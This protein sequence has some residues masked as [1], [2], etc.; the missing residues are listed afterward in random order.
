MYPRAWV[1]VAAEPI[2]WRFLTA[3]GVENTLYMAADSA[4]LTFRNDTHL[5]DY[6]RKAQEVRIWMGYV[7]N[8][9]HWGRDELQHL[10]TGPIDGVLPTFGKGMSVRVMCRDYSGPLIDSAFT[11]SW[12]NLTTGEL[13]TR[14]FRT[15]G[16]NP[17]VTAT[18]TLI[19]QEMVHNRKEW[20]V[21][22]AMADRDGFVCYVDKHKNGYYGP[23]K[24]EDEVAIASLRYRQG[25]GSNVQQLDFDDSKVGVI[26]RA[27]VRHYMGRNRGYVEAVAEDAD[28]IARYGVLERVFHDA[29]AKTVP[30]AQQIADKKLKLYSRLS[31]TGRGPVIG[32]PALRAEAK[33]MVAGCGRFDGPYYIDRA[34]HS[35]DKH[36]GY[37][38]DLT[39]VN[40]RPEN[41][42]QYRNDLD[43][44]RGRT[45]T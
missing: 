3:A 33:V 13:A 40:L 27:V 2:P 34:K 1:E 30:Q 35:I 12:V 25:P 42:F 37:L 31:V 20:N 29:Q 21:L 14:M 44:E 18:E 39:L 22:Q 15:R 24:G 32:H 6:L 28:H 41:Q 23:R 17:V 36:N 45:T 43:A 8:P 11:G 10:F 5:S 38:T 26:N 19:E 4:E 7:Q 9:D 16:L